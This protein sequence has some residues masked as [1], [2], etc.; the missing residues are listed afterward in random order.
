MKS[1]IFAALLAFLCAPLVSIAATCASY[2]YTLTNGQTADAT[3]VMANFNAV[4]G[5]VN[6]SVATAGSFN[7]TFFTTGGTATDTPVFSFAV[8]KGAT[9]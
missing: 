3:Q 5:C 1:F 2:P 6:S 9:S 8:I 7:V 4:L